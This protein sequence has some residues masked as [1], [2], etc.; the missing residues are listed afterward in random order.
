MFSSSNSSCSE[1][2]NKTE[3]RNCKRRNCT[4]DEDKD[5]CTECN[6]LKYS[7]CTSC[8]LP[9]QESSFTLDKEQKECNPCYILKKKMEK[10]IQ[11]KTGKKRGRKSKIELEQQKQIKTIEK[12][13]K[14]NFED[15]IHEEPDK[16]TIT[17]E[18]F[19]NENN[20]PSS[21]IVTSSN[22]LEK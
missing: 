4:F 5:I 14:F 12:K 19:K 6:S 22:I 3:C 2:E 8:K 18:Y 16:I 17:Y 11:E 20:K 7:R 9:R 13:I 10:E 1:N 15:K 21:T